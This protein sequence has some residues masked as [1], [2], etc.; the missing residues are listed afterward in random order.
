MSDNQPANFFKSC[1]KWFENC[2]VKATKEI[3]A[4]PVEN[5]RGFFCFAA[6]QMEFAK[7][8]K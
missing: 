4:L 1:K 6:L 5:G 3:Q 2:P 7:A 8:K